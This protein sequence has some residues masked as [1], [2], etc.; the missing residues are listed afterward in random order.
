MIMSVNLRGWVGNRS[1]G[2][3]RSCVQRLIIWAR[4]EAVSK[5]EVTQKETDPSIV[6]M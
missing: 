2:I 5:N 6:R 4:E 1:A 3:D